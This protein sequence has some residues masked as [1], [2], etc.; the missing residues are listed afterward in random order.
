M[1]FWFTK[2]DLRESCPLTR[3]SYNYLNVVYIR[4]DLALGCYYNN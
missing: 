2:R 3:P 1:K 4:F